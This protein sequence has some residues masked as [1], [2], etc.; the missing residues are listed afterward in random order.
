M[1]NQQRDVT[2]VSPSGLDGGTGQTPGLLRLE[3]ISERLTGSQWIWMGYSLLQPGL[4]TGVHHHGDS[5]TALFVLSGRGR[6]WVGEDLDQAREAG[7][8]DFVFIP[9]NVVHYEENCSP[10]QAVEMIVARSTQEAIV[11]NLDDGPGHDLGER[12]YTF[13]ELRD[14]AM[15]RLR[16]LETPS[17]TADTH[18]S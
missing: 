13:E 15:Q 12:Q 3:A 9:P 18:S 10:D 8:G 4:V 7:P 14:V 6:W 2:V 1:D 11:V 17:R 16:A 5:E